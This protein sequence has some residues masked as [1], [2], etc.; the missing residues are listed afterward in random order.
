MAGRGKAITLYGSDR[1]QWIWWRCPD[2]SAAQ[3]NLVSTLEP[4]SK[5]PRHSKCKGLVHH[6]ARHYPA[7]GRHWGKFGSLALY[8]ARPHGP[9]ACA[10][11]LS[12]RARGIVDTVQDRIRT[13]ALSNS[14]STTQTLTKSNDLDRSA[15]GTQLDFS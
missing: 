1:R 13:C 9:L 14:D 8:A 6:T 15:I 4:V 10:R 12:N 2:F 11:I 7:Y 3:G 5:V